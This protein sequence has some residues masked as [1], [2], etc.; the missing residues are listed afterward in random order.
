LEASDEVQFAGRDREQVYVWIARTLREQQWSELK[1]SSRSLV[2]RYL[3]KMTGL[4]RAQITRLIQL[5]TMLR[6]ARRATKPK[7][8]LPP[9][10]TTGAACVCSG[11]SGLRQW[12]SIEALIT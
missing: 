4:S 2:R 1:R 6:E 12:Q 11:S 5:Y 10:G 3:Q 7:G 9:F 8:R